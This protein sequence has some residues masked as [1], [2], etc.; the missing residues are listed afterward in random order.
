MSNLYTPAQIEQLKRDAKRI[1]RDKSLTHAVALDQV[2]ATCG[3]SN[4]SRLAKYASHHQVEATPPQSERHPHIFL[5]TVE[6]MRKAMRKTMPAQGSGSSQDRLRTQIADLSA[7]F[8]SAGNALD[9]AISYMECALGVERFN[10]NGHSLVYYEMRCWLP[11]CVHV[12]KPNSYILL[13]RDYKPVGMTQKENHIDYLVFPQVHLHITEQQWRQQV[14]VHWEDAAEGYLYDVSPWTSRR[15]AQ[16]Y[17]DDL[18][19]LREWLSSRG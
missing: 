10:V 11:Y 16:T 15:H 13:G 2:A 17:L 1:A 7:K 5:R 19:K 8:I 18:R 3:H 4:W 6:A 12:V 9:F 14:T